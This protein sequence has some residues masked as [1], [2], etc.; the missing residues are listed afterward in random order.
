MYI[1]QSKFSG[2]TIDNWLVVGTFDN[3]DDATDMADRIYVRTAR[4][5]MDGMEVYRNDI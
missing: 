2:L 5:M 4:V 1:V 3:L